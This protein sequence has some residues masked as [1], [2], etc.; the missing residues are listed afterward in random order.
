MTS[1]DNV[2][3]NH[4]ITLLITTSIMVLLLTVQALLLGNLSWSTSPN[5]TEIGHLGATVYFWHTGKFDVFHV[6]PP[7]VRMVAGMPIAFFCNPKYDWNAYSPRP[8]DRCEW[9][10]GNAF[11]TANTLDDL[12]IY[13][14][15]A[16]IFCIPLV[17]LG[18]YVGF[19][20]ATELYGEWSGVLFLM[21]WTFSPLI[22]G[23]GATICPDVAATSMGTVGL[24]TFWHWLKN[25]KWKKA[26]IAGICLGLMPL[27]KMTWIIAPPIWLLLWILWRFFVQKTETKPP[28]L[29]FVV[30]L[31]L[32]LYTINTGY[33][34]DG[35]LK[36]LNQYHFISGTLTNT[37]VTRTT[38]VKPDNRFKDSWFGSIP[39]PLPAEFV[40][41]IDTQKR[42][43]ERGLDSYA[44][45]VWSDH[46]WRWYYC[47]VLMLREPLGVWCLAGI[48]LFITIFY[49]QLNSAWYNEIIIL[50]PMLV[51]LG[52]ISSQNGF[53]IHPR[54][55]IPVLPF[56]YIFISKT[57]Q[58]LS[59]RKPLFV[60]LTTGCL[61]WV[62]VHSL[63][64]YPHSMSYFNELAGKPQ[65]R[66]KYLLGSNIDWGQDFY[67]LKN[68]CEKHPEKKP[69]YITVESA[70]SP[71]KLGI[72][73][74]GNVP[75]TPENGWIL[76]SVNLLNDQTEK[77]KWLKKYEPIGMI[78]YSIYIYHVTPENV[79]RV[80][81][82]M[83]L[84]EIE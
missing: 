27:T 3:N 73:H 79:N 54:Y 76:I 69:R 30:I 29:Q 40:Q 20:F 52:F 67:E 72:E 49:R 56:L 51:I 55:I 60:F 64:F 7:L 28:F 26:I 59:Q 17:L 9:Q 32:A 18:G 25:P 84:P 63:L 77:Y 21:L 1:I 74:D 44:R 65:N 50:L 45:G 19:R 38:P 36:L 62:V 42:D 37:E 71:D 53:S 34:F 66:S 5:R 11:V 13:V 8:Q 75:E 2:P 35:S 70:I 6:N 83:R 78:G 33:F 31:L 46:G 58:S 48:A 61:I 24:Y 43:F 12:R 14:F 23:W 68:W 41:G 57:A 82:K 10:L 4:R 81:R 22:L 80:Q 16:R 39:I 47:Y 15:L